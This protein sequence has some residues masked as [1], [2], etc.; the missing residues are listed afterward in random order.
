MHMCVNES[1]HMEYVCICV[2]DHVSVCDHACEC[3]RACEC[4]HVR[5]CVRST[6]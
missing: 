4:G 3:G 2:C 5:E 6:Q 1:E